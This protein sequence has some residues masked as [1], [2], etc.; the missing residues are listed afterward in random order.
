[1]RMC[2]YGCGREAKYQFKNGKWCCSDHYMKCPKVQKKFKGHIAWNKGKTGIYSKETLKK[3]S[4]SHKSENLSEETKRK[5]SESRR[6]ENLSE[7]T[8]RKR[9]ESL[10][11]KTSFWKGKTLS[12]ETKRKMSESRKGRIV[13][14]E[15]REKLRQAAVG[16]KA[17]EE[18][19][20]KMSKAKI[21]VEPWNKGLH[22][23]LSEETLHKLSESAKNRS[24]ETLR[25]MSKSQK[26][27]ILSKDTRKKIG[28]AHRGKQVSEETREKLR[29]Y[30][31]GKVS[32][33]RRT[34]NMLKTKYPTFS[35]VEKMRYNPDKPGEKEIQVHCKNHNCTNSKEMGG[36][37][38]PTG[39][40]IEYRVYCL[41]NPDGN[42][43][44]YFYCCEE[45]KQECPLYNKSASQLIKE[46]EIQQGTYEIEELYSSE[47]Y[48]IFRQEVLKRDDYKCIYCGEKAEH[49]HHI[50]PQK[51]EPFFSLD[52]DYAISVCE[53]CHYKYGHKTGTECSTGNLANKIC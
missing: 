22:N 50:R 51:L 12:E 36:W 52:P 34:I 20:K 5:I 11:G 39:R 16:K 14:E 2:D 35:K 33:C 37:F 46:V 8:L 15:T 7:E 53:N 38:T 47:E 28:E 19:K 27:R 23:H 26:G 4:I 32:P 21:G 40:Q 10:K 25:K 48:Q 49:V 1:M 6:K 31:L 42:D 13:S 30:N 41:E 24:E 29:Q 43:G 45:C 17:S 18:T 9:S 44:G 3:M